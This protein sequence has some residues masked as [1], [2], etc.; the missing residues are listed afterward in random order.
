MLFFFLS[1]F[2]SNRSPYAHLGL[3]HVWNAID[4]DEDDE[5]YV[6][7]KRKRKRMK[8]G[9]KSQTSQVLLVFRHFFLNLR[10]GHIVILRLVIISD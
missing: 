9:N 10:I 5:D 3:S 8:T 4:S 7:K 1:D 6:P 2:V